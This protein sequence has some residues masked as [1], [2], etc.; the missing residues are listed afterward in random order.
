MPAS[1]LVAWRPHCAPRRLVCSSRACIPATGGS[2]RTSG[3]DAV[4]RLGA[5]AR[6]QLQPSQIESLSEKLN[7]SRFNHRL[8]ACEEH[9]DMMKGA[10]ACHL[11]LQRSLKGGD[12]GRPLVHGHSGDLQERERDCRAVPCPPAIAGATVPR[13]HRGPQ[14]GINSIDPCK[15]WRTDGM[16]GG[17]C[18]K[19]V[20]LL[21]YL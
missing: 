9:P 11:S 5:T 4:T 1:S 17:R 2:C 8:A 6:S 14:I 3:K 12:K 20:D 13:G 15:M 18:F 10:A 7:L 19:S 21:L 16:L